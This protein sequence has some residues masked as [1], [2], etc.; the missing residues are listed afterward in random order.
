VAEVSGRE[1]I[2]GTAP[3]VDPFSGHLPKRVDE[4]RP[5]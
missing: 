5:R 4:T 1:P 2:V 3:G